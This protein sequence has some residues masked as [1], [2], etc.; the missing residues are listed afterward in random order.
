MS[1]HLL[2]NVWLFHPISSAIVNFFG[3]S[4]NRLLPFQ[5]S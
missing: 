3:L 2:L 5:A 1:N 4:N